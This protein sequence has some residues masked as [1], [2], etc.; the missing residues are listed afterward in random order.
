MNKNI[1][2]FSY[3]PN[4][5]LV[6]TSFTMN[7]SASGVGGLGSIPGPAKSHTVVTNGLPPLQHFV[8]GC[9]AQEQ[10]CRYELP[11]TRNTPRFITRIIS[12]INKISNVYGVGQQNLENQI[13]K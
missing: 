5:S 12:K 3:N 8:S 13:Y 2:R 6:H 1:L 4:H 10:N 9:L 11:K 7:A